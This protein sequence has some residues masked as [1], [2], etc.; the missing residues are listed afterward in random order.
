MSLL[1]VLSKFLEKDAHSQDN[2]Y[3]KD[4]N[5]YPLHQSGFGS[6]QS[7]STALLN[8]VDNI[9]RAIDRKIAV[10]SISLDY[11]KAFDVL[12]HD[13][14][15]ATLSYLGFGKELLSLCLVSLMGS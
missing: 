12:D 3:L 7:T 15:C 14:M 1:P 11:S 9:I 5:Y 6:G 8:L 4:K 2:V 13:L 10:V